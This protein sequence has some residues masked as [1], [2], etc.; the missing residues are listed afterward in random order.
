MNLEASRSRNVYLLAFFSPLAVIP[1]LRRRFCAVNGC[2]V[3]FSAS[4]EN[5]AARE[6]RVARFALTRWMS[7]R[8]KWDIG[9]QSR[10][11][12]TGARYALSSTDPFYL[13]LRSQGQLSVLSLCGR[14]VQHVLQPFLRVHFPIRRTVV[15]EAIITRSLSRRI[16]CSSSAAATLL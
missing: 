13:N 16:C 11:H 5:R 12:W 7:N 15:M 9:A 3:R 14:N 2:K 1:K 6:G 10:L 8:A 4:K